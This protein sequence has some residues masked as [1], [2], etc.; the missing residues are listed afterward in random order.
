MKLSKAFILILTLALVAIPLAAQTNDYKTS[1]CSVKTLNGN[2]GGWN[3]GMFF[4][5]PPP[6]APVPSAAVALFS[7]DGAGKV[8]F[9]YAGAFGGQINPW[10]GKAAGTYSV[11]SDCRA[12]VETT[13]SAN[14]IQVSMVGTITGEGMY[15]E[16][17]VTYT[18]PWA[19]V[20][21]TIRRTPA[22]GC[23]Q[24]TINGTYALFGQGLVTLPGLPPLLP[25]HH[26]GIFTA[27]GKGS[28]EGEDTQNI[29]GVIVPENK[30]T[31]KYTSVNPDCTVTAEITTSVGVF[32]EVGTITGVGRNQEFH[33]I[34]TEPGWVFAESAKKQ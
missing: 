4:L 15:Q 20:S 28:F 10:G 26:V 33:F 18:V 8:S 29:A 5:A 12:T 31:G 30:F 16:V 21:G 25:G 9:T 13:D 3:T 23:S 14:G 32:H 34:M 7:F 1:T 2:Y 27:D 19:V 17:H 11:T 24:E 22:G 6:A